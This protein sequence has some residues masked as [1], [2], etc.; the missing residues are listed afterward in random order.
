[1]KIGFKLEQSEKM[2]TGTLSIMRRLFIPLS[3]SP[4]VQNHT[5]LVRIFEKLLEFLYVI[6]II[7]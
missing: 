5:V 4:S 3:L 6:D 2:T 1:M 7:V